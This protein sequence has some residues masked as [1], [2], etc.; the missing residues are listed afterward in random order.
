M[1]RAIDF[2]VGRL[3]T[4]WLFCCVEGIRVPKVRIS[5]ELSSIGKTI[6]NQGVNNGKK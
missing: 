5:V 1:D 2:T 6:K 4:S 3:G